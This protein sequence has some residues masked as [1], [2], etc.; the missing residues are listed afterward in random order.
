MAIAWAVSEFIHDRIRSLT[1]FATHYHELHALAEKGQRFLNQSVAVRIEGG[2]IFFP[3]RISS[4]HSSK[5]YGIDVAKL[6]GVPEVVIE[7]AT[8]ILDHWNRQKPFKAISEGISQM[9]EQEPLS[10]PLFDWKLRSESS[11]QP[12][13]GN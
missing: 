3:H 9:P 7:R 12:P 2:K 1:L 13:S 10:M 6:A 4:G 8:R 5:S 11:S